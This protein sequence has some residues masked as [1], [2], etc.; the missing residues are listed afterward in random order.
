MRRQGISGWSRKR[1]G[2]EGEFLFEFDREP[3]EECV[4]AL[5]GIRLVARA[6]RS[7][8]VPGSVQRHLHLKRRERGFDQASCVGGETGAGAS[9]YRP[10]LALRAEMNVVV[11]DEFRDGNLPAQYR[12]LPVTQRAFQALAETIGERYFRGDSACCEEE[13]LTWLRN[14]QRD[15]GPYAE[16]GGAIKECAQVDYF[17]E[18]RPENRCREPLRY[19]AIRIRHKQGELFAHGSRVKHFAVASK[20]WDWDAK[21]LPQ[22]HREKA[23]SIEAVHDAIKNELA[24]GVLPCGRTATDVLTYG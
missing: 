24:G 19:V 15:N 4:T 6:A 23:G 3:L 17:P 21:K 18:E 9:G 14:Q 16:D 10:V 11:A 13:L 12:R 7:L 1:V 5:G 8:D 22:W 2:T 20:R